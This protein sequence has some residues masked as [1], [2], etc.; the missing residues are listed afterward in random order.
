M[1]VDPVKHG[2][3]TRFPVS[4][5]AADVI[6]PVIA[7]WPRVREYVLPIADE[8]DNGLF[9][10][11][12]VQVEG[13]N[14]V[15]CLTLFS[16]RIRCF[17]RLMT[18]FSIGLLRPSSVRCECEK[19]MCCRRRCGFLSACVGGVQGGKAFTSCTVEYP[20]GSSF[21]LHGEH[22]GCPRIFV[23]HPVPEEF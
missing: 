15:V 5:K 23:R 16:Q 8:D 9:E 4:E 11:H 1:S 7:R 14:N 10:E 20:A 17:V 6:W 22:S 3:F 19:S 2:R 13:R 12:K 18:V 21:S